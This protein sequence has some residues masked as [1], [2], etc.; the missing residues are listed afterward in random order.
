MTLRKNTA[1]DISYA[2]YKGKSRFRELFR[3]VLIEASNGLAAII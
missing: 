1:I 3:E 2:A